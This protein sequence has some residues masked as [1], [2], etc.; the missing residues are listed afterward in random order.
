LGRADPSPA[1]VLGTAGHIDHGKTALIKALTGVDTDRLPEE[2]AR[3]ITIDLGFAPLDL[4]G[5]RRVSVIDVPGHERL[6][7]T[8]V[9]GAS[10]IDMLLLVVAADEGVMPQTREHLSICELLGIERGVVALTK[11][12][13][14]DEEM[15]ELAAEEVRELLASTSLSGA[16]VIPVSAISG[17][18]LAAL[19]TALSE[20]AEGTAARTARWGPPRLP[21]D[22]VFAVKGFG[23]VVT[24]TLVGAPLTVS[25]SVE[26]HPS[27]IRGKIRGL[28]SH[29]VAS[30]RVEPGARCAV[31]L[32]G[33]EMGELSRGEVL[34]RP[35]ALAPTRAADLQIT[36][37]PGAPE[38]EGSVAVEFLTGST[39]RRAHLAPIGEKGFTP[40]RTGFA[41][42]HVDADPI[43]LL[44]GDRFIARG[45]ARTEGGGGTL[46]G[47]VVLDTA[48]PRRRRSDPA[49]L[50][51]L[52]LL[53]GGDERAG[54][55][56]RI[57]RSGLSGVD[58]RELARETGIQ[59]PRLDEL[60]ELL[61]RQA[62]HTPGS[63]SRPWSASSR[64]SQSS[65]T[66]STPPS[67][68]DPACPAAPFA[69]GC[70]R[71]C[72]P[73]RWS[74]PSRGSSRRAP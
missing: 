69:A 70:P 67:R 41:R 8:M 71:T 51:E 49:L 24:G 44:P 15:R 57:A 53:A 66:P 18:G 56:E 52:E 34:S 63:A 14:V 20:L 42:L 39:E 26:I 73:R 16:P 4:E 40:G 38:A 5:D 35:G 21:I 65:S 74:W 1:L 27:G 9:S 60:L 58:A 46:G 47:G 25:E 45:F 22:R 28:Q 50:R 68:S 61:Q 32:Q 3:G 55:R 62:A 10:G 29:G 64:S 6:V 59:R 2:Q 36:W 12:D 17:E 30:Q 48:P 19:R 54:M 7:R 72:R 31:N 23:C 37:L 33:V 11:T 13:L 43:P